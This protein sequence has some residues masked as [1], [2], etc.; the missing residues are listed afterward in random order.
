MSN[1]GTNAEATQ[2]PADLLDDMLLLFAL[3]FGIGALGYGLYGK[4]VGDGFLLGAA[5]QASVTLL[6][7]A[8][9]GRYAGGGD[10]D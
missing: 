2:Q 6:A 9:S 5:M 4:P 1:T 7:A 10:N 3:V 8:Y